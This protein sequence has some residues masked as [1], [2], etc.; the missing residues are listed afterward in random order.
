M[1]NR[2]FCHVRRQGL[3]Y[4]LILLK[5]AGLT[6][7][8]VEKKLINQHFLRSQA[9]LMVKAFLFLP[10]NKNYVAKNVRSQENCRLKGK[11][12]GN[13]MNGKPTC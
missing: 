12:A 1:G 9:I 3:L 10:H 8:T 13:L 6:D 7:R 4:M 5:K 11:P 2:P